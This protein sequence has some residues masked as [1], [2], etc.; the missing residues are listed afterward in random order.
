MMSRRFE[1]IWRKISRKKKKMWK[2]FFAPI[3]LQNKLKPSLGQHESTHIRII[4]NCYI[5]YNESREVKFSIVTNWVNKEGMMMMLARLG[6]H[7]DWPITH[8]GSIPQRQIVKLINMQK[9]NFINFAIY[10]WVPRII[11]GQCTHC[12][13][14]L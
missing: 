1:M 7:H 2:I 9:T 3:L 4:V 12:S 5:D 14:F 8:L 6:S 10:E 13:N 11:I